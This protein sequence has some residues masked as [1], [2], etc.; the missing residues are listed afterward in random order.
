MNKIAERM[1]LQEGEILCHSGDKA[2]LV[3]K[4]QKHIK[5]LASRANNYLLA[6][7][8]VAAIQISILGYA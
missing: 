1:Q 4:E 2:I 6:F 5:K 8:S 7:L 3:K